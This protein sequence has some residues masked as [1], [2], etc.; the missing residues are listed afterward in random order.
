MAPRVP[1]TF[2]VSSPVLGT[3]KKNRQESIPCPLLC[4]KFRVSVCKSLSKQFSVSDSHPF[5]MDFPIATDQY[6]P[7]FILTT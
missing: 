7:S 1:A 6:S 4:N 3:R 5:S 2:I